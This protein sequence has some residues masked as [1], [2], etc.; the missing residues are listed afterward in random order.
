MTDRGH[1]SESDRVVPLVHWSTW[2]LFEQTDKL[3][4]GTKAASQEISV[5]LIGNIS[6]PFLSFLSFLIPQ[7]CV[8]NM[9][10][11]PVV[12]SVPVLSVSVSL[13][14][15]VIGSEFTGRTMPCLPRGKYQISARAHALF[16]IT[17]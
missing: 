3:I 6:S 12:L 11:W 1:R 7:S 5:D 16:I 17:L 13:S 15:S 8:G 10:I 4:T 9:E 2:A 14:V